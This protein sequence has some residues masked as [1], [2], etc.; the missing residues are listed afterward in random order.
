MIDK[1]GWPGV[2]PRCEEKTFKGLKGDPGGPLK[3]MA[4]TWLDM[5]IASALAMGETV[6]YSAV[7]GG[8]QSMGDFYEFKA[9]VRT[10]R[11]K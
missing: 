2:M 11:P 1:A 8:H 3:A 5:T 9:T 10:L 7:T 6:Q 4:Q